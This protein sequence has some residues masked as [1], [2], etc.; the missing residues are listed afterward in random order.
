MLGL[1]L[2]SVA[3]EEISLSSTK[4]NPITYIDVDNENYMWNGILTVY[5]ETDDDGYINRAGN[6]GTAIVEEKVNYCFFY[7]QKEICQLFF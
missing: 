2:I 5:L 6:E 3:V 1:F 4:G 7:I